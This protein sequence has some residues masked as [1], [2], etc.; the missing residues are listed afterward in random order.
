MNVL[1]RQPWR[2]GLVGLAVVAVLACAILGWSW[3]STAQGDFAQRSAARDAVLKAGMQ[4]LT[5]LNTIDHRHAESDVDE[6]LTVVTDQLYQDLSGD[7]DMHVD[8]AKQD[9]TVATASVQQA[10]VS[11]LDIEDGSAKMLAVLHIELD[12]DGGEEPDLRRSGVL[13]DLLRTPDG[14]KLSAIQVVRR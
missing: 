13:A 12:A 9:R 3:W 1:D 6:W 11:E 2:N 14:W 5:V 4:G 8:R 10:A 7:R